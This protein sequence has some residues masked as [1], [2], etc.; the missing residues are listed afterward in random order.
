MSAAK[1]STRFPNE[2]EAYRSARNELL[3]AEMELRRS[4]ESVAAL[5]RKLPLG[6]E[7]PQDYIFEEADG[8]AVRQV[9]L[10]QLFSPGKDTLVLYSYMYGPQMANPCPMCTSMLD[11]LNAQ[12]PHIMQRVNLAVA[13]KSPVP[14][15]LAFTQPRGWRNLRLLSSE[16][17]TYNTDY[18]A[19]APD[20]N[21]I[22]AMNVFVRRDG[23]IHHFW[24]AE[25]AYAPAEPGQEPRHIDMIW[26]LWNIF[27]LT[28][29]GRGETWHP[30]LSY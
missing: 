15:I 7:V 3:E 9:R 17:S 6:G 16:K 28:P 29:E 30:K 19:E 4:V 2:A 26:P 13:A 24:N 27:D 25:L 23:R 12:A 21:Q 14:R 11:S 8:S 10:S 1:H 18:H 20:G 5:R 22:P